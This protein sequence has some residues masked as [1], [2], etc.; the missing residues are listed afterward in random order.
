MTRFLHLINKRP[1]EWYCKN[2]ATVVTVAYSLEFIT[3]RSMT[4]QIID[5]WYTLCMMGVP[6]DYQSYTFG[7]NHPVIHQRNIPE[8]KLMKCWNTLAFHHVQE[9]I[10][11]GFLQ[12]FHIP[13]ND[14]TADLLT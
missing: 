8:S 5:L 2:H 6:L 7:D 13:S 10:A 4:D 3:A 14:N 11:S 12:L 1:L 9:A